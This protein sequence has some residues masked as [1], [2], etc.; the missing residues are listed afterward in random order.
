M[1]MREE[2]E[3]MELV[4]KKNMISGSFTEEELSKL[5][6]MDVDTFLENER[7]VKKLAFAILLVAWLIKAFL[8]L[9]RSIPQPLSVIEKDSR[10]SVDC[11]PEIP[12]SD[13]LPWR[14]ALM[15]ASRMMQSMA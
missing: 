12:I 5:F 4:N 7:N 14:T 10:P 1:E 15:T 11:V 2:D 9:A 8:M 13:A 6:H 3:N